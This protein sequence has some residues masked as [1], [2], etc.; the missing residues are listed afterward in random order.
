MSTRWYLPQC[1]DL[2]PKL[3]NSQCLFHKARPKHFLARVLL[4]QIT[5]RRSSAH[6][7]TPLHMIFIYNDDG[8]QSDGVGDSEDDADG[9]D[10]HDSPDAV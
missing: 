9:A 6:A 5:R 4:A 3:V 2:Q 10:A 8:S 1:N 7:C